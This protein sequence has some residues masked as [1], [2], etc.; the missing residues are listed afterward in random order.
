MLELRHPL[1]SPCNFYTWAEQLADFTRDVIHGDDDAVIAG[2]GGRN[3]KMVTLVANS[4]G[5]MSSLQSMI[6]KPDL[7]NGVLVVNP[8]FRELHSAEVPMSSLVMPIVQ[9]VQRALRKNS[10]GLFRSLVTSS[11]VRRILEEPYLAIDAID[12]ELVSVLLDPLLTSGADDV[13]VVFDTLSYSAGPLPEQQLGSEDF[14]R[15]RPVWVMYGRDD[16]WTLGRRV[17]ALGRSCVRPSGSLGEGPVERIVGLDGAGHCPHDKRPEEV[18]R[19]IL[20]F[21]DRLER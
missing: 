20:E 18:N 19:L 14:P 12:D 1:G 2:G 4:I 13:V 17:E 11:T 15:D 8:N 3:R 16:P 21:L 9:R 6:N 7:Y 10:A 5:T